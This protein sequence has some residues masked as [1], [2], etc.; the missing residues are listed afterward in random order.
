MK[1]INESGKVRNYDESKELSL[2][3]IFKVILFI[4]LIAF[5]CMVSSCSIE[6]TGNGFKFT[7][8]HSRG[9]GGC[10]VWY[11]NKFKRR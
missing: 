8:V 10:G 9:G 3:T 2:E 11:A 7:S 1:F 4:C 6:R 5:M